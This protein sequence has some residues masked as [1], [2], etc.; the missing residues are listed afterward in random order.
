MIP[1]SDPSRSATESASVWDR[2]LDAG[3]PPTFETPWEARAFAMVVQ[4]SEAGHF[5]WPEW[6]S[7][8]SKSIADAALVE[9][10]D[11]RPRSYAE[12]WIAA[13]EALLIAKG[14]TSSEQ[15]HARRLACWP[16]NSVHVHP[17]PHPAGEHHVIRP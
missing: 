3:E 14:I 12:Q 11:G 16:M 8:L 1:P 4:L 9:A 5:T 2:A 17:S 10:A 7:F 13:A 6:V 15:L